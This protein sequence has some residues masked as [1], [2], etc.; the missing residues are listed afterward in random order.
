MHRHGYQGRKFGRAA[1]PR[2][3][4]LRSLATSLVLHEAITTTEAKAKE[5]RPVIDRLITQAKKGDLSSRRRVAAYLYEEA[6]VRKLFEETAPYYNERTSGFTRLAKL[7]P[8]KGDAAPMVRIELIDYRPLPAPK[9]E[10]VASE[11]VTPPVE[12][13]V[14]ETETAPATPKKRPRKKAEAT[15]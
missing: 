6:A 7:A 9:P 4:L 14:T 12:K 11:A 1:G 15:S 3:A 10:P 5:L 8:R 13:E 2:R